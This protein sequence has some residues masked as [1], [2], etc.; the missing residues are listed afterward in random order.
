MIIEIPIE[1]NN[2]SIAL[3]FL[4]CKKKDLKT[5]LKEMSYLN[6]MVYNSNTKHYKPDANFKNAFMIMSEHDEIA[7]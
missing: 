7:S 5:K 3:E 1:T 4:I 2:R 6:D